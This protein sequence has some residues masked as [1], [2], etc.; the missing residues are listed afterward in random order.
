MENGHPS[1]QQSKKLIVNSLLDYMSYRAFS[2][3]KITEITKKAGVSRKTF[4][5]HFSSKKN[6]LET[7]LDNIFQEYLEESKKGY[8]YEEIIQIFFKV[9][10]NYTDFVLLVH[11]HDLSNVV[12]KRLEH[13][14]G[15]LN[16]NPQYKELEKP[17]VGYC[18]TFSSAGMWKV[19]YKWI[20]GGLIESVQEIT[21]IYLNLSK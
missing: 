7:Y 1:I 17:I 13:Y 19:L 6:I 10:L 15:I 12:I 11:T 4:Y 3:V 14:L 20:E 21:D 8:S 16:Q 18:E 5:R 2:D 9:M